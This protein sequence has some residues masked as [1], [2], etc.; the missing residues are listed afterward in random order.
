M[1]ERPPTADRGDGDDPATDERADGRS[2]VTD[3]DAPELA[4]RRRYLGLAVAGVGALAGCAQVLGGADESPSTEAPERRPSDTATPPLDTEGAG[5]D[6]SLLQRGIE[7]DRV[8][9]AV[10]DLG[11][12]PTG[13]RP[14]TDRLDAALE[15][16]TLVVFPEGRYRFDGGIDLSGA[17]LGLLGEG[18]VTFVP[19]RGF[20]DLLL[21][22]NTD[23]LDRVLL[24]NIDIDIRSPDTTTGIRLACTRR[25]HV[26][27]VRFLGRGVS[28]SPGGT[29]SAF[30][31]AVREARGRGVL[32]NAVAKKGSRIDGY[33]GGDGRIGVWVGWSNKGTVRIEDCD[34][35]EFGNNGIYASRTP[36]D[37][38]VVD[39]YFLNNN[40]AGVRIGGEGSYAENCTVEIDMDRY[41]GPLSRTLRGL[42]TRGIVVEG[43][44]AKPGPSLPAGAEIRGC[45]LV[46]RSS[47]MAQSVIEQSPQARS[48]LVVDTDVRC[49]IDGTPAIR[50]GPP[51]SIP[52]RPDR[53]TP[54][55]PH[56]TR[57]RN[58]RVT[59]DASGGEA[60]DLRRAPASSLEGCRVEASGAN[61]DGV[62]LAHSPDSAVRKSGIRTS[63][64]PVVLW[65]EPET[66]PDR[67]LLCLDP[68]SSL[69]RLDADEPGEALVDSP[70]LLQ[71]L[72][73]D[74]PT[75]SVC[76]GLAGNIATELALDS[77]SGP[78]RIGITGLDDGVPLG[79]LLNRL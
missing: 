23:G 75:G 33:A 60:V 26:Q 22:G 72:R 65:V 13:E 78:L 68:E 56:W 41:T 17:R 9:D 10:D 21:D 5:D 4:S 47:P 36:G 16:G 44:L 77:L 55:L 12:D 54:P 6:V 28:R 11:L 64:Q 29:V 19:P 24:E 38:E 51:G 14:V 20:S 48:L 8:V 2:R 69:E 74:A 76:L 18:S 45:T 71:V 62:V 39:S 70:S 32:R 63:G 58:V 1:T 53:R 35:R 30:L 79:T 50:R 73:S 49:D 46:A 31:L 40:V 34:F 61:R 66:P 27:D 43:G 57:L 42:N 15:A 59:G 52:Y 25:F 67:R 3:G 7:F 37:V